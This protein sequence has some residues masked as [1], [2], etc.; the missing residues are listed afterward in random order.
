MKLK[1]MTN[2]QM[3]SKQIRHT[4][5]P[6]QNEIE[7]ITNKMKN[8]ANKRISNA[9]D[10]NPHYK[11]DDTNQSKYLCECKTEIESI[12]SCTNTYFHMRSTNRNECRMC[13]HKLKTQ[14]F[15]AICAELSVTDTETHLLPIFVRLCT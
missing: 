3:R 15:G 7:C 8:Q 13:E 1:C 4:Q 2:Y 6:T 14:Q 11:H 9:R 12:C 5:G 10:S